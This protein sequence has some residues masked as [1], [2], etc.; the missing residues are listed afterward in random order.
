[1][2]NPYDLNPNAA[3]GA[4]VALPGNAP[5]NPNG[6]MNA[7]ASF[8]PAAGL[9]ANAT[10]NPNPQLHANAALTPAALNPLFN[11]NP[12]P[13]AVAFF[14]SS[15]L[16]NQPSF[17]DFSSAYSALD[18][19][20]PR[21]TT[22]VSEPPATDEPVVEDVDTVVDDDIDDDAGELD[23]D[24]EDARNGALISDQYQYADPGPVGNGSYVVRQGDC[25]SSIGKCHGFFSKTLWEHP[26]NRE[27]RDVRKDPN[28]LLPGDRV[29]IPEL[30][31][32]IENCVTEK[33]HVFVRKGTHC[34]FRMTI[35]DYDRPRSGEAYRLNVDGVWHEG[36]LDDQGTLDI[37]IPA[38]AVSGK[39]FV[40]TA[41]L[42]E[43]FDLQFGAIDPSVNVAGIQKRLRNLGFDCGE[44]T[45][46]G[47]KTRAA[48][49]QFQAKHDLE[50]TG[51]LD[52]DSRSMLE[53]EHLS[54]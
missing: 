52:D 45:T 11:A 50:V 49:A 3:L 18:T 23:A 10:V 17:P 2:A 38:N 41:P 54:E 44:E 26:E 40:G 46:L 33:R 31:P 43:C 51:K 4:N 37:K 53:D 7:N 36:T 48:L 16:P 6:L 19:T 32:R 25:L 42:E 14:H 1:M 34:P 28:V 13:H 27:L 20:Y 24:P 22:W 47:R 8:N 29:F 21:D 5:Y 9:T 30:R 39:L 12:V 35:M 15:G